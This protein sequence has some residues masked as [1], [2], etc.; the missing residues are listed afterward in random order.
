MQI[1]SLIINSESRRI[2]CTFIFN[3]YGNDFNNIKVYNK[4][5]FIIQF[6]MSQS[7]NNKS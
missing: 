6:F 1:L 4:L 2:T 3:E 5:F 7:H